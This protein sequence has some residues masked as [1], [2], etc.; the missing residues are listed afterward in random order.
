MGREDRPSAIYSTASNHHGLR[1][2][3]E[4]YLLLAPRDRCDVRRVTLLDVAIAHAWRGRDRVAAVVAEIDEWLG[5]QH[6]DGGRWY[7]CG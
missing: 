3:N 7:Y 6:T 4:D 1:Q 5:G 2:L